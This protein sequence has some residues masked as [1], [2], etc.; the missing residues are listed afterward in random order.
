MR[1]EEQ[2]GRPADLLAA[3]ASQESHWDPLARSPTGVRGL[4]MLTQNTARSLGVTN[5][6]DPVQSIDGGA[7]YLAGRY[8][9]LPED[10]P[11][12]DRIFL[13]LAAYNVGRGHVLD[14]RR[15]ARQLG[16]NPD[17]W[18]DM[19]EVLPLLADKRY[20]PD[21]RHGYARG[22]EPVHLVERVRNYRDVISMAFQ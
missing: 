5:R 7:R 6:L 17:S 14:A 21:L 8:E 4:M 20:Y 10:I 1:A 18:S 3:L 16:K 9:L 2:T 11:D 22:Y 12:P 13:A 15:L 19:R